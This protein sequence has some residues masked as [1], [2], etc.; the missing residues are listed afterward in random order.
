MSAAQKKPPSTG[1]STTAPGRRTPASTST[2]SNSA[3]PNRSPS[4]MNGQS[5]TGTAS[6]AAGVRRERSVRGGTPLSAR[7]AARKP[8]DTSDEDAKAELQAKLEQALAERD[9]LRETLQG[10]EQHLEESQKQAAVLQ[11]KLDDLLRDQGMLED[12][13]HESTERIEE[14]ENEK[15]ESVRARRELE[16]IYENEQ[17]ATMKEKEEAQMR[18]DE[19]LSAMQRM[20]ETLAQRELRDRNGLEDDRRPSLSRT[21]SFRSSDRSPNPEA[22]GQFAPPSS[23]QRSDSRSSSRLVMQKDKII[24]S[25]RLEL[26]EAQIRLVEVENRGGGS[27]QALEREILD[28]KVVNGRLMEENESFQLLLSEKTLNGEFGQSDLLRAPTSDVRPPSRSPTVQAGTSLADE[29][30]GHDDVGSEAGGENERRLQTEVTSLRDQNKALTLY[31]NNIVSRLLQHEQFEQILDKTPDL[32]AGLGGPKPPA[33]TDKELPPP[34]PPKDEVP[35]EESSQGGAA[36]LLQRAKS[37]MGGKP[38]RPQST[39]IQPDQIPKVDEPKVNEDPQTAPRIPLGRNPSTRGHKRGNSDWP[40]ASVVTSMY[41]GPS[42]GLQGPTSP[43]LSSPT[44]G[45]SSFFGAATALG[46]G[47]RQVSGSTVPTTISET[48]NDKDSNDKSTNR[49]SKSSDLSDPDRT[50]RNSLASTTAIAPT[51][52]TNRPGSQSETLDVSSNPS[53]PPRST[54]SSG[55]RDA[56]QGGAIMMGSKPRPLR[57][58]QGAQEDDKAKKAANRGSWF[59]WMNKGGDAPAAPAAP[60]AGGGAGSR[61]SVY[62]RSSSGG[63][64]SQPPPQ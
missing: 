59:G 8:A 40:A 15:K 10:S 7:A 47:S 11:V 25:L 61:F 45:R 1:A 5:G 51:D 14:L 23:L 33:D 54:T 20:K 46:A 56:R 49:D 18:E 4:R 27:L 13:V 60:G 63:D 39:V 42:P 17:A 9:E 22:G 3:A 37:V 32:M 31:I 62:G 26:A 57:L 19:M 29:L 28:L 21:G 30:E 48:S 35:A 34:P 12:R 52:I 2:P 24:E 44:S 58:V 36:G 38:K 55:D 53:S 43:G 6:A 16:Q 64:G 41:K 50:N